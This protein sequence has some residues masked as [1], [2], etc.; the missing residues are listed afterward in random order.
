MEEEGR[1][2]G[3]KGRAWENGKGWIGH[4]ALESRLLAARARSLLCAH[5]LAVVASAAGHCDGFGV[6]IGLVS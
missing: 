6:G 3:Y 2:Q 4:T 1:E 5:A